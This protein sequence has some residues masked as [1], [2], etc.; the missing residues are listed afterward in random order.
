MRKAKAAKLTPEERAAAK[1]ARNA[2]TLKYQNM[3]EERYEN[4]GDQRNMGINK[5]AE[6][7]KAGPTS[8][9]GT[10]NTPEAEKLLMKNKGQ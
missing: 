2:Q 3:I 9:R 5:S 1:K 8:P 4:P 7:S 10:I 6:A